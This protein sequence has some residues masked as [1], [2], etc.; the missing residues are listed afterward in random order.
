MEPSH[1]ARRM[2]PA[3]RR[4]QLIETALAVA[5][6]EGQA[7][8]GFEEVAKRAGVTRNLLYHYFPDGPH[9]LRKAVAHRVG[10]ERAGDWVSDPELPLP[11]RLAANLDRIMD[12]AAEPC[13]DWLLY[14][15]DSVC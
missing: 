11:V 13:D 15:H 7:Q 6:Q 1:P 12:H 2:P 8:V 4:E 3:E 5:A 10:Q 9:G 14:H